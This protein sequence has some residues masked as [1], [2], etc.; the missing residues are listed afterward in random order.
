MGHASGKLNQTIFIGKGVVLPA[1][2]R[3][4]QI[5]RLKVGML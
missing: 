4:N 5:A 2:V 1:R 3:Q